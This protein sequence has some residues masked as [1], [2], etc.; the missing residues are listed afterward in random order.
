MGLTSY[1]DA[2]HYGRG[3]AMQGEIRTKWL[4]L[5][6]SQAEM[7]QKAAKTPIRLDTGVSEFPANGEFF[8]V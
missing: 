4:K 2:D 3:A 7:Q 1:V 5:H 8:A 6:D